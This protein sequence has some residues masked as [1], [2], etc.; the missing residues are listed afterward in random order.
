MCLRAGAQARCHA[1]TQVF[2]HAYTLA[3]AIVVVL[4]FVLVA[5]A[6]TLAAVEAGRKVAGWCGWVLMRLGAEHLRRSL[7][8]AAPVVAEDGEPPQRMDK[9]MLV[10]ARH[11]L[12]LIRPP[13]R[14]NEAT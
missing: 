12:L 14:L 7:H 13:F 4:A 3:L 2:W 1:G 9:R 6:A 5:R 8:R 10:R 11:C